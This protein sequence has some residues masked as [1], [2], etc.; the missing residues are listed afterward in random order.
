MSRSVRLLSLRGSQTLR[1]VILNCLF[2]FY[3]AETDAPL[4]DT[5]TVT[6][7]SLSRKYQIF[8]DSLEREVPRQG[9]SCAFLRFHDVSLDT[10]IRTAHIPESLSFRETMSNRYRGQEV[11]TRLEIFQFVY[12]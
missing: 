11:H 5:V 8:P 4:S 12:N 9:S 1:E 6:R 10:L 7:L 2:F 3:F